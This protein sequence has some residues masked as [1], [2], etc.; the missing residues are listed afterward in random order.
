MSITSQRLLL[1][2]YLL[3]YI[4]PFTSFYL[5]RPKYNVQR[6]R[7]RKANKPAFFSD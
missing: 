1:S 5:L 4:T 2:L 6:E 3:D 7:A